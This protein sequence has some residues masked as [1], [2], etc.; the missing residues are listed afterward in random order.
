MVPWCAIQRKLYIPRQNQAPNYT[1][2]SSAQH[3]TDFNARALMDEGGGDP[4][5]DALKSKANVEAVVTDMLAYSGP[6][7]PPALKFQQVDDNAGRY[8]NGYDRND[9]G[10]AYQINGRATKIEAEIGNALASYSD[11]IK[12]MF[13][14]RICPGQLVEVSRKYVVGSKAV[15]TPERAPARTVKVKEDLHQVQLTRYGADLSMNLNLMLQ[16]AVAQE[17]LNM[18]L[19]AQKKSLED[20]LTLM[21]YKA[22]LT[23]TSLMEAI[24]RSKAGYASLTQND[25]TAAQ[26]RVYT[27]SIF[28]AFQRFEHPLKNIIAACKTA[29]AYRNVV[30]KGS[31]MILPTATPEMLEHTKPGKMEYRI[32]GVKATDKKAL[33]VNLEDV[34][35]DSTIG[36]KL[37]VHHPPQNWDAGAATPS[38]GQSALSRK[39]V[40]KQRY[41]TGQHVIDFTNGELRMVTSPGVRH[42]T[43]YMSSAVV[44]VPGAGTGE[45]LVG[46]PFTSCSTNQRTEQMVIGLRVYLGAILKQ[47]ENV[48]V[49]PDVHID[50]F[51]SCEFVDGDDRNASGKCT[52]YDSAG[53]EVSPGESCLD[54]LDTLEGCHMVHGLNVYQKRISHKR[55]VGGGSAARPLGAGPGGKPG[56]T[57]NVFASSAYQTLQERYISRF[58]NITSSSSLPALPKIDDRASYPFYSETMGRTAD[59]VRNALQYFESALTAADKAEYERIYGPEP[60]T[61]TGAMKENVKKFVDIS[62]AELAH[63]VLTISDHQKIDCVGRIP[64]GAKVENFKNVRPAANFDEDQNIAAVTNSA[65]LATGITQLGVVTNLLFNLCTIIDLRFKY[66]N[67]DANGREALANFSWEVQAAM[68]AVMNACD[69]LEKNTL[70]QTLETY[71][72]ILSVRAPMRRAFGEC[73]SRLYAAEIPVQLMQGT[74]KSKAENTIIAGN[75]GDVI[76]LFYPVQGLVVSMLGEWV[77][78]GTGHGKNNHWFGLA[79]RHKDIVDRSHLSAAGEEFV[80]TDK[81]KDLHSI[82]EAVDN[83]ANTINEGDVDGW[84]A[85]GVEANMPPIDT[86]LAYLQIFTGFYFGANDPMQMTFAEM[87]EFVKGLVCSKSFMKIATTVDSTSTLPANACKPNGAETEPLFPS[88]GNNTNPTTYTTNRLTEVAG[89][90]L[91]G[92]NPL[93]AAVGFEPGNVKEIIRKMPQD[94]DHVPRSYTYA[95]NNGTVLKRAFAQAGVLNI[96]LQRFGCWKTAK[97]LKADLTALESEGNLVDLFNTANDLCAARMFGAN[98]WTPRTIAPS[99]RGGASATRKLVPVSENVAGPADMSVFPDVSASAPAAASKGKARAELGGASSK[100]NKKSGR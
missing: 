96:M 73:R 36:M 50:S 92:Q 31:L 8:F 42:L 91:K 48:I 72:R 1:V 63:F 95:L 80:N 71:D 98:T 29:S 97:G 51:V 60:Y 75:P 77:S 78:K 17:E 24:V 2:M 33:T 40:I 86:A 61:N 85:F 69:E 16:P 13:G 44:G 79:D 88:F 27:E 5:S 14:T 47:K 74:T 26:E 22:L 6:G 87:G 58:Y 45:L 25:R 53:N 28:A 41:N 59:G 84:Y 93:G 67:A 3:A 35:E 57:F 10:L 66:S 12:G 18:K 30:G 11:P 94:A 37:M 64:H 15:P 81:G 46:Y 89:G 19:D 7:V 38:R 9:T 54:E 83:A 21:G 49:I 39:V 68:K 65:H 34:Y 62:A 4:V 55:S 70:D 23:G 20:E 76:K 52:V 32:S 43:L 90:D 56:F 100:R 82:A 99:G